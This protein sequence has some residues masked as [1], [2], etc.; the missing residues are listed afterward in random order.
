MEIIDTLTKIIKK[1]QESLPNVESLD[2]DSEF[3]TVLHDTDDGKLE[4][5]IILFPLNLSKA[6]FLPD[7]S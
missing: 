4:I 6:T 2:V 1:H 7:K 3:E 5:S